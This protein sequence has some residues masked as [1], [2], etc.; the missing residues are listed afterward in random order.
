M[1][2]ANRDS[3][4]VEFHST[5]MGAPGVAGAL[6]YQLSPSGLNTLSTRFGNMAD[7]WAHFRV[8]KLRFRL[9]PCSASSTSP[10]VMGYVGGVQDTLPT[11]VATVGELIPSCSM[12]G[13]P[14]QTVPSQWVSPSKQEL[15][16]P[17]PWYKSVNGTADTTEEA[18]GYLVLA[19]STTETFNFELYITIEFKISV[20]P[21]NTPVALALRQELFALRRKM[22]QAKEKESIEKVLGGAVVVTAGKQ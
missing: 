18:P 16:G 3:S 15:A 6:S 8:R 19:G 12:I 7:G 2:R 11:T 17:L 1:R 4:V 14:N 5:V 21:A 22:A 13:S 20:D 10:K 9:L